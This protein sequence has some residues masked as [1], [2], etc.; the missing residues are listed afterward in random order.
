MKRLTACLLFSLMGLTAMSQEKWDL[1]RAIDYALQ[2]NISVK[3]QDIQAR[4]A[5]LTYNQSKLSQY[6]S[7]NFGS[8]LGLNTGRNIDRTTNQFTTETTL[9]NSFNLQTNV[10]VFN[11]F[12]KKNAIAANKL[13]MEATMA[14]VDKVKNDIALNVAG[15]YLQILLNREQIE[16]SRVQMQQTAAQLSNTRKLVQAG[17]VPELNAVQLEAQLA[18]DSSNVVSAKGAEAQSLLLLKA[19]LSLDAGTPFDITTPAVETIP[20]DPISELQPELVYQAALQNLPQQ[21]VNDLRIKAAQ[22]NAEA[23]KGA[24]YPSFSLG[25]SLQTNYSNFKNQARQTGAAPFTDTIGKVF[26]S[27]DPVVRTV[28]VPTYQ[29]YSDRYGSQF[30]NNFGN[31]IGLNI[32]VPI[33]NGG[34][35]RT[36]WRRAKLNIQ[37]YE[38]QQQQD[39]L[40]LKQ[41]I[42]KAYTDAIT[43]LE[44]FNAASKTVLA[45][46][47]AF[48]FAGKR[49]GIGLLSTIELTTTQTNLFSARLQRSLAQYDFVFKMKVLEFYKGQGLRL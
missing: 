35:A 15:T 23:A 42:Y 5:A 28:F 37:T 1:K 38:F 8:N 32:S 3:Q 45:T 30:L 19:L 43:S 10:D 17:S 47:R 31:G 34:T 16:I 22:K 14:T 4:F 6:P 12:S 29:F 18:Q 46:E 33:F 13:D 48:D 11:F 36:A 20:I 40:T 24:M 7:L 41:D 9:Y 21:R 25:A 39:N 49:Y 2:N 27:N 26:G 44:K